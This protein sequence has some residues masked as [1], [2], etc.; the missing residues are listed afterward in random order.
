MAQSSV[1]LS[2]DEKV[3]SLMITYRI[4][5][6]GCDGR[7]KGPPEVV[8]CVD[9]AE[10]VDKAIQLTERLNVEIWTTSALSRRVLA[11]RYA[12]RQVHVARAELHIPSA[13][14]SFAPSKGRLFHCST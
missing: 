5:K 4:C 11:S 14:G 1:T 2:S 13:D 10:A 7:F 6:I 3:A 8:D 9:D 12:F